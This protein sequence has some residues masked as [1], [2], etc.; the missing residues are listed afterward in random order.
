MP[1][2]LL[3]QVY[4]FSKPDLSEAVLTATGALDAQAFVNMDAMEQC[5]A[6]EAL[7]MADVPTSDLPAIAEKLVSACAAVKIVPVIAS[8]SPSASTDQPV[9]DEIP[10]GAPPTP[11]QVTGFAQQMGIDPSMFMM[12]MLNNSAGGAMDMDLSTFLPLPQI[13][14]GYNP[15]L[16][17]MSLMVMGQIERRLDAGPIVVINADGSVNHE[18]TI[19]Y[20]M[21]L[22]E[23]FDAA[24]NNIFYDDDGG[25]Y[26]LVAV[27]VDAQSIYDADPVDSTRP[28]QKNGQGIGRIS[29]TGI[30]LE[31]RQVVYFAT[32][33]SV[34][35]LS[36]TAEAK[37]SWLRDHIKVGVTVAMLGKEFPKAVAA[38]R[39]ANRAGQAPTLRV[40][41]SRQ[42][43]RKENFP[44]RRASGG[45]RGGNSSIPGVAGQY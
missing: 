26:E 12:F 36:S 43:R 2:K 34:N 31:V 14:G 23:G 32:T 40:Q 3:S 8:P 44:R 11:A 17:N 29:W 9:K 20:I 6:L 38:F 19:K 42:P 7:N 13:V 21:Q 35:E 24:E 28:L 30:P 1:S 10:E 18:L 4:K 16:R 45:D 15:K 39:E 33:P 27:G 41:L 25:Q 22:E 37:L 5:E